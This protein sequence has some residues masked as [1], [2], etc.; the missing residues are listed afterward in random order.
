MQDGRRGRRGGKLASGGLRR[1]HGSSIFE[2]PCDIRESAVWKRQVHRRSYSEQT[3]PSGLIYMQARYYL[4]M[5]GRFASP[6]PARDQHFEETQSWNIYSYVQNNPVMKIDPRGEDARLTVD[7]EKKTVQIDLPVILNAKSVSP[8][9]FKKT[10]EQQWNNGGK[11]YTAKLSKGGILGALGFKEDYKVSFNAKVVSAGDTK[12]VD[13]L[14]K[15]FGQGVNSVT[16]ADNV[17]DMRAS[18]PD[19]TGMS[20]VMGTKGA[21]RNYTDA[22]WDKGGSFQNVW[23]HE[24][25]H[26]LGLKDLA[27]GGSNTDIMKNGAGGSVNAD[28]LQSVVNVLDS[29]PA[30]QVDIRS[31]NSD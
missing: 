24:V 9:A 1:Y 29:S 2:K 5:Y 23:S 15:E 4:P 8:A 6:D 21:F 3:D 31:S 25:G 30:S 28:H 16:L 26:F 13:G 14:K 20:Q 11:G 19:N 27:F 18:S 10:I 22:V 7:R 12:G 17:K